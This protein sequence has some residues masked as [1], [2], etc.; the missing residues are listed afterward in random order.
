MDIIRLISNAFRIWSDISN[1]FWIVDYA[2]CENGMKHGLVIAF[3]IP[4]AIS[5]YSMAI[6]VQLCFIGSVQYESMQRI[7]AYDHRIY[8]CNFHF[9]RSHG[10]WFGDAFRQSNRMKFIE[11]F[12]RWY[13][14]VHQLLIHTQ[15]FISTRFPYWICR[16]RRELLKTTKTADADKYNCEQTENNEIKLLYIP[17]FIWIFTSPVAVLLSFSLSTLCWSI[18]LFRAFRWDIA[19]TG[20]LAIS[21]M[22][23]PFHKL[24][25]FFFWDGKRER[26]MALNSRILEIYLLASSTITTTTK[27]TT[28]AH[29]NEQLQ[30]NR[31]F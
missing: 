9:L 31:S 25:A 26:E 16:M 14:F 17:N 29:N 20:I 24:Q 23:W 8:Y 28:K 6:H 10:I 2:K 4:L 21:Y 5:C 1:W 15:N 19:L 7:Y 27:T 13:Y 30:I 18:N 3:G 12:A 11:H 22:I